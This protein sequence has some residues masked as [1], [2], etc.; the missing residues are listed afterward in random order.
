MTGNLDDLRA[1]T[2]IMAEQRQLR[3]EDV[4]QSLMS[5]A[6][7]VSQTVLDDLARL[8]REDAMSVLRDHPGF[9][10]WQRWNSYQAALA[11]FEQSIQ[12]LFSAID[13]LTDQFRNKDLFSRPYRQRL[14]AGQLRVHKEL[15]AVGNAAH[16]LKDHASYRLQRV[17]RLPEFG[18]KLGEHFGND[19][20]HDFV[21][22]LRTITH[23]VD[24]VEPHLNYTRQFDDKDD[25]V[26]F[27]L[28][29]DDLQVTMDSVKQEGGKFMI[30]QAGLGY[31]AN[32]PDKIDVRATYEEYTR[33][34]LAFH[35]WLKGVL[36]RQPPPELQDIQR[37]LKANN[38]ATTRAFWKMWLGI[39][40]KN[41]E[42]PPDPYHFLDQY[43]T[44][45]QFD[46]VMG[47]PRKSP[48]QVDAIIEF[49]DEDGACDDEIRQ[50]AYELFR[51]APDEPQ[52]QDS[53]GS[54][55]DTSAK[56]S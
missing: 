26:V 6:V 34:A 23:H 22:G 12:D 46:Q 24:V 25:E 56:K 49:V 45:D 48:Q 14:E 40:L 19:G 16:S 41:P 50:V 29:R 18:A 53:T 37:C 5:D 20:L 51:K 43:L 10:I 9:K 3:C 13:D 7:P 52:G 36:E 8:N 2:Q 21:I 1:V 30:N 44:R 39:W 47:L 15:F 32:S 17:A 4:R 27:D 38:D 42:R 28:S 54:D 55:G 35:E 11:I 31:L 33:R